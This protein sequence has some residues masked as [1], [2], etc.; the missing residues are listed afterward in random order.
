[1]VN[2]IGR[3]ESRGLRA[4]MRSEYRLAFK[5]MKRAALPM[6]PWGFKLNLLCSASFLVYGLCRRSCMIQLYD[7]ITVSRDFASDCSRRCD[8]LV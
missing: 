2:L 5:S 7:T 4:G 6:G 1:M 3:P 8:N